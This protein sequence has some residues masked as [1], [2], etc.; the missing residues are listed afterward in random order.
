MVTVECPVC[1]EDV[2]IGES[3]EIGAWMRCYWCDA[4]LKIGRRGQRWTLEAVEELAEEEE[5]EEEW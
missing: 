1:G 5:E 2:D 3:P 4:L